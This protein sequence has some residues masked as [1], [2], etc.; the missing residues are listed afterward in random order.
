VKPTASRH[1]AVESSERQRRPVAAENI[2][3][4]ERRRGRSIGIRGWSIISGMPPP[5][6]P[7]ATAASAAPLS[8]P[9]ET[10][11]GVA[12]TYN[13]RGSSRYI[14][15]SWCRHIA[16]WVAHINANG[17]QRNLGQFKDEVEAA[18]VYDEAARQAFGEWATPN[19]PTEAERAFAAQWY[20]TDAACRFFG[21]SR[22]GWKNWVRAGRINCGRIVP[23]STGGGKRKVYTLEELQRLKE[24]LFGEDK[25]CK[26]AGNDWHVPPGWVRRQEA[27]AMFGVEKVT[28][29]RWERLGWIQ[30]GER[31]PG[32]P[33]VYRV[34]DI[35]R[36]IAQHGVL[37]PPYPDPQRPGVYRVPLG[38]QTM[39]RREAIIDAETLPLIAD[40]HCHMAS[41]SDGVEFVS[42]SI[43]GENTPLRRL[44]MGVTDS[45][46]HIGHR[47]GDPLDCRRENLIVRSSLQKSWTNRKMKSIEGRPPTSRY[48]GVFWETWT[49]KWRARIRAQGKNHSL[50]RFLNE[51]DAAEAY[52]IA[53]RRFFGEHAWLN[54][55]NEGERGHAEAAAEPSHSRA[56]A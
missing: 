9:S 43:N 47:D 10:C 56:A 11:P 37:S 50:G 36:L 23:S 48:K 27:W 45:N 2:T 49:G 7:T 38:S 42:V 19:F 41:T 5:A 51:I 34:E 3:H 14:G 29:E 25:L 40:G 13:G 55:P 46:R 33:K 53:A 39:T 8:P 52:D 24:E 32:G 21:L 28:W 12:P 6:P 31:I 15:V 35:E 20:D 26:D 1:P 17:Q 4:P 18:K 16:R 22:A 54:F 44:I 30:C